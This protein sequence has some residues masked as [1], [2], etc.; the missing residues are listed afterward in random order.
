MNAVEAG[1]YTKLT[2]DATLTALLSGGTASVFYGVA[3][4]GADPPYLVFNEQTDTPDYTFTQKAR[5][6]LLYQ[7]KGITSGPSAKTAGSIAE[8]IE[9]VL[10]D[11]AL[12]VSGKTLL[13]LRKESG[14]HYPEVDQGR[15]FHHRGGLYRIQT[16]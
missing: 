11:T 8:R 5:D 6:N 10:T 9:S 4:D 2:G 14:V 7:V 3:P 15:V 13:Y 1:L 16:T 12:T